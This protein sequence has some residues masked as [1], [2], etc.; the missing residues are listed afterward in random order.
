MYSGLSEVDRL[1]GF[2]V[3]SL[4]AVLEYGVVLYLGMWR[5]WGFGGFGMV[6]AFC[7]CSSFRSHHDGLVGSW[8]GIGVIQPKVL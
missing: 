7:R 3:R 4:G 6:G 2:G 8:C 5:I 1:G